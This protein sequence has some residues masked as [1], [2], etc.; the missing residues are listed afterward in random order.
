[1]K[2]KELKLLMPNAV[3]I[4]KEKT[5]HSV[6]VKMRDLYLAAE[7]QRRTQ[8]ILCPL[9]LE[10]IRPAVWLLLGPKDLINIGQF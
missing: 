9:P 7:T 6:L 4:L 1:M 3:N 10:G 2:E 5:I 8:L